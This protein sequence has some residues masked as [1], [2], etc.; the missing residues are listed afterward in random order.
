MS[1]NQLCTNNRDF[2]IVVKTFQGLE[3]LLAEEVSALTGKKPRVLHRAV[4]FMGNLTDLYRCNYYLRTAIRVL[5]TIM[6]C[7][8]GTKEELYKGMSNYTWESIFTQEQRMRVEVAGASEAFRN[9]RYAAQVAK[10][11]IVDRFR[12]LTGSRPDVDLENPDI[13][14]HLLLQAD[15][16][17]VSLDSSGESLHLRGYRVEQVEAPLSEVLAAALVKFSGWDRKSTLIDPM[18]G[19]GTIPIEAAWQAYQIPPGKK[20]NSFAFQ[21]WRDHD[22]TLWK[23]V[24]LEQVSVNDLTRPLLVAS[25]IS[26]KA[27]DITG[28]N[29]ERA[30]I[31]SL[32]RLHNK[33]FSELIKPS[34]SGMII[35]NPPYGERLRLDDQVRFYREIGNIL[36]NRFTGYQAWVIS[37][38]RM[39][40]KNIGLRPTRKITLYNGPLESYFYRFDLYEG[41]KVHMTG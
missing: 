4:S 1:R 39:A 37:S 20:R 25:D 28:R 23:Q 29:S 7:K 19:S 35:M 14:I 11:G 10:D 34:P 40:L 27:I 38:N 3:H 16:A 22:Q 41:K 33:P 13:R 8:A 15:R 31:R 18:C 9:T 6:V 21:K 32:I 30:G 17:I 36:K 12:R 2:E 26:E 5:K 24:I